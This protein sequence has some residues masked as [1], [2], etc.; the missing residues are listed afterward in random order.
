ML[1]RFLSLAAIRQIET[2]A[3]HK[4]KL[5]LMDL[6]GSQIAKWV[7][8]NLGKKQK[9]L[10]VIGK[11]NNGGDGIVAA[12]KLRQLGFDIVILPVINYLASNTN[13]LLNKFRK[14][15]GRVLTRIPAHIN[16]YD[17]VIDAIFGIGLNSTLAP[18]LVKLITLINQSAKLVLAVDT[19][20][21]L[22][23]FNGEV[24]GAAIRAHYTIT[25]IADKPGFYTGNGVDLVGKVI[26]ASLVNIKEYKLPKNES[27][28]ILPNEL[29]LID[30]KHLIRRQQNTNKGTFGTV[31][32]IGGNRGMHGA[33]YLAGRSAMLMGCGKVI[34]ASIDPNFTTDYMLPELITVNY[35]DVIKNLHN[36][37]AVVVGPGFGCDVKAEKILTKLIEQNP[38]C[39]L[40]FDADALNI[41]AR[42]TALQQ[43]FKMLNQKIITPHP[44]EASRLLGITKIVVEQNRFAA[45]NELNLRFNA[46]TLLKGAGS[47]ILEGNSVY[48]N[49]TG[50]TA[51]SSSGQGD[52]L[53]GMIAAFIAQGLDLANALK[54]AVYIHGAAADDMVEKIGYNGLLASEIVLNCRLVLNKLLYSKA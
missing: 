36:F 11:G 43:K 41:V 50:N 46:I 22:N 10:V 27:L 26:V 6:A 31:V 5:N 40:I 20:T 34:L 16:N 8:E 53:C 13:V 54:F 44:A 29:S 37:N 7:V 32:I 39:K 30:Y 42:N 28:D 51:L 14:G 1:T 24:F 25:F 23:P 48:L 15:D 4:H 35:K 12:I 2:E 38:K 45:I 19:P 17:V 49:Q 18:K 47:L 9:F 33:L 21:G 3:I 52:S